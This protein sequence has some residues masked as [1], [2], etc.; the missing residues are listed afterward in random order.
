MAASAPMRLRHD[1]AGARAGLQ[2]A[3]G[4]KDRR[5]L[6]EEGAQPLA[7]FVAVGAAHQVLQLLIEMEIETIDPR[8]LVDQRLGGREGGGGAGAEIVGDA[9]DGEIECLR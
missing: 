6:V 8:R 1:V 2:A 3:A 4:G 7:E 9:S 5:T